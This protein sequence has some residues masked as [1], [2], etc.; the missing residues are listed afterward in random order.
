VVTATTRAD[1]NGLVRW[2]L[3]ARKV[4]FGPVDVVTTGLE[5]ISFHETHHFSPHGIVTL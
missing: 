1:I 2:H 5:T 4:P 3:G